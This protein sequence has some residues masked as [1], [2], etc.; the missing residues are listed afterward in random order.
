[1]SQQ[2]IKKYKGEKAAQRGIA[3]MER[4]GYEVDEM[5]TRKAMYSVATGVFTRKQ[6]H[7]IVFKKT[8]TDAPMAVVPEGVESELWARFQAAKSGSGT[9]NML[10]IA[11]LQQ[12]AGSSL[13]E[14]NHARKSRRIKTGRLAELYLAGEV[15]EL[16]VPVQATDEASTSTPAASEPAQGIDSAADG[17][18]SDST[19][20]V[21]SVADELAKLAA[22]RDSGVLSEDEF[23]TQKAKLLMG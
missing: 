18:A 21:G 8:T 23:A 2:V 4:Q 13:E 11:L 16:G 12:A 20:P 19:H 10:G 22:L 1:M 6:I 14:I 3:E 7:T 9:Q 5:S 15:P 17:P